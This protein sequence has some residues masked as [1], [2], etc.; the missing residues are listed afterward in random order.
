MAHKDAP[1]PSSEHHPVRHRYVCSFMRRLVNSR[2]YGRRCGIDQSR[3]LHRRAV[4]ARRK[5]R[6]PCLC[7]SERGRRPCRHGRAYRYER[8]ESGSLWKSFGV[9]SSPLLRPPA[10]ALRCQLLSPI[11]TLL[12]FCFQD[13]LLAATHRDWPVLCVRHPLLDARAGPSYHITSPYPSSLS[14]SITTHMPSQ[15]LVST[16]ELSFPERTADLAS[17][18]ARE[19]FRH[20]SQILTRSLSISEFSD[21]GSSRRAIDSC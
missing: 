17:Q 2:S 8:R 18:A 4:R 19:S 20:T 16:R 3:K 12:L 21:I 15:R 13:I 14:T 6:Q 7:A 10:L 5:T 11:S 9:Y 1:I